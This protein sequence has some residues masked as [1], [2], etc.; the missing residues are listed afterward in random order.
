[1]ALKHMEICLK[2]LRIEIQITTA[3][4]YFMFIKL[5]KVKYLTKHPVQGCAEACALIDSGKYKMA[6]ALSWGIWQYLMKLNM[7][8]LFY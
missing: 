8:I 2:S 5:A 6:K 3:Q 1:M 7:Y 4:T